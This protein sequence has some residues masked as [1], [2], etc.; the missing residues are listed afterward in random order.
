LHKNCWI[1]FFQHFD[2]KSDIVA[3]GK[4]LG[5]GYP[6][7]VVFIDLVI[8]DNN[9][10]SPLHF[11]IRKDYMKRYTASNTDFIYVIQD[12]ENQL[13]GKVFDFVNKYVKDVELK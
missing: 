1:W 4:G 2:I 8:I 6:V 3:L 10:A 5:N 13:A 7:S 12:D 11:I 9:R